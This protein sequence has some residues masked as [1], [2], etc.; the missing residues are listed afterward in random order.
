MAFMTL[1]IGVFN[2]L[3]LEKVR[4]FPHPRPIIEQ[5]VTTTNPEPRH[6][7]VAL[8][9]NEATPAKE[10]SAQD[11]HRRD[12]HAPSVAKTDAENRKPER[13]TKPERPAHLHQPK[14]LVGQRQ[15]NY[16]GYGSG[17]ALGYAEGYRP[18]LDGQ[19]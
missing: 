9:T 10:L 15:N 19:R 13:K 8:G 3:T 4:H 7:R 16:D 2:P 1:L 18:G 12:S 6:V 17:M 14:V 11:K 5:A